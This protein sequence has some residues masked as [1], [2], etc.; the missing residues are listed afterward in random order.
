MSTV[1]PTGKHQQQQPSWKAK[2]PEYWKG[3]A[4]L[5]GAMLIFLNSLVG[6][7][8]WSAT[9]QSW[10]STAIAFLTAL[11]VFLKKNVNAAE[12]VTG[13]DID[14]DKDIGEDGPQSSLPIPGQP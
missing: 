14:R 1:D 3:L 10:I 9:A 2:L 6:L 11:A 4:A 8:F 5:F 13:V 12:L 7:D